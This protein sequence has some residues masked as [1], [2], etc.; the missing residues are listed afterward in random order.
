MIDLAEVVPLLERG[1]AV[2]RALYRDLPQPWLHASVGEEWSAHTVLVH[3][4]TTEQRAWVHRIAHLLENPGGSIPGVNPGGPDPSRE[5]DE[6][7]D[8]FERLRADNLSRLSDLD[9]RTVEGTHPTLGDVTTDNI[10]AAWAIHDLNHQAQ[11]MAAI[12]GRYRKTVGPFIP[13]L[14]ILG[15]PG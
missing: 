1:P 6:M 8:E 13:N 10:V 12:A 4:V 9:L 14:G 11:A 5:V 7:L 3:L 15:S 2:L